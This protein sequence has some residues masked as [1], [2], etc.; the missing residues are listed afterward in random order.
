METVESNDSLF[1]SKKQK[2][3]STPFNKLQNCEWLN[4]VFK[5][6]TYIVA[7]LYLSG[8]FFVDRPECHP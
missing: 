4:Y 8:K 6:S 1:F 3:W 7:E 5:L 2:K